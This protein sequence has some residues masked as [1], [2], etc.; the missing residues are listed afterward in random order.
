MQA[1][2]RLYFLINVVL[3]VMLA[4]TF[5][6]VEPGSATYVVSVLAFAILVPSVSLSGLAIR[7]NWTVPWFGLDEES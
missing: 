7:Y 5:P 3:L 2:I 1:I 6:F 4:V